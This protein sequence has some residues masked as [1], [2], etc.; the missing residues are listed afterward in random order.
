VHFRFLYLT[1][2]VLA[3]IA[4]RAAAASTFQWHTGVSGNWN[5]PANWT[6]VSG[7][8]GAGYPNG[9][10]DTA[11]FHSPSFGPFTVTV[12]DGVTVTVENISF[13]TASEVT[14]AGAGSGLLVLETAG[15]EAQISAAAALSHQIMAVPIQL[16]ANLRLSTLTQMTVSSPISEDGTPRSV[17]LIGDVIR[18]TGS[19]SNTYTGTTT[20]QRGRLELGRTNGA[21]AIAGPLTI[22]PIID[23]VDRSALAVCRKRG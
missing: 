9:S 7:P 4:P 22:D 10:G 8:A 1:L 16:K 23:L 18:Y 13:Q 11:Q 2:V 12:P 21:I 19:V 5:D 17:T 3:L 6:L 20:L 15:A 14:I